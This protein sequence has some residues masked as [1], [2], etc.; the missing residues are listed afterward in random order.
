ML[1][2]NNFPLLSSSASLLLFPLFPKHFGWISE[3]LDK[4]ML[5]LLK[6]E[7]VSRC[8]IKTATNDWSKLQ[9]SC[10][11]WLKS[12]NT[13]LNSPGLVEL[14]LQ[15]PGGS[16]QPRDIAPRGVSW[17]FPRQVPRKPHQGGIHLIALVFLTLSQK[18]LSTWTK[19]ELAYHFSTMWAKRKHS[20]PS[21]FY[22]D[23]PLSFHGD[24]STLHHQIAQSLGTFPLVD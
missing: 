22:P 11:Q 13:T 20:N 16:G 2:K 21:H 9:E 14:G 12:Q 8:Q 7:R 10:G 4:H 15:N 24:T 23:A 6:A 19:K 18:P 5:L 1:C 3:T 17:V